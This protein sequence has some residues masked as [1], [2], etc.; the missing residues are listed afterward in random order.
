[1]LSVVFF[2]QKTAYEL[3]ISDWSSDVCS[4]DLSVALDDGVRLGRGPV[5]RHGAI[6][7]EAGDSGKAGAH[8]AGAARPRRGDLLVDG[9]LGDGGAAPRVFEPG[10]ELAQRGAVVFHS[11]APL[12]DLGIGLVRLEQR[13]AERRVGKAGVSTGRP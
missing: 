12:G 11:L 9:Q 2:K 6:G 8:I 7:I 13:T 10:E 1:M 5:V 4:S 3:R